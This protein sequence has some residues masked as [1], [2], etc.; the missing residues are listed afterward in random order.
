MKVITFVDGTGKI[1]RV[2]RN[3]RVGRG[4]AGGLGMLGVMTEI[5]LQ[6]QPGLGKA[7][8]WSTGARSDKNMAQELQDLWVSLN[9]LLTVIVVVFDS[10]QACCAERH[11]TQR[12]RPNMLQ[13]NADWTAV[14]L[15]TWHAA[16]GY[17][18]LLGN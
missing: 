16:L 17:R 1:N 12:W 15:A 2:G 11:E 14:Q 4:L 3:S 6:L 5:T 7:R 8:T 9:L 10:K 18:C 13:P